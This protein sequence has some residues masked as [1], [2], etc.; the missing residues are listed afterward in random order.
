[1]FRGP[2]GGWD[3]SVADRIMS[4]ING[5]DGTTWERVRGLLGGASRQGVAKRGLVSKQAVS[6]SILRCARKEGWLAR[7]LEDL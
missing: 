4:R 2:S 1:M 5:I 3:G 7:L 6:K